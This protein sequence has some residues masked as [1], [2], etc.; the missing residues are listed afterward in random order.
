MTAVEGRPGVPAAGEQRIALRRRI[1]GVLVASQILGGLGVATGVA[2]ASVLAQRISG[3]ESLSG[4][5]PTAMVTGTAVASLPLAALMTAR[6]RRPGLVVGYLVGALGA[7]VVVVAAVVD[8]FPL[9]LCGMAGFGAAS[10][11]NL[12]ARFAAADLAEPD[13]RARAISNVVWATTIGAVLGPNIAAPAGRSVSGLGIPT[14][15][16]PFLWAAGIF[17]AAAVTVAVLLRPD[18]L[19]TARALAPVEERSAGGRSLRAGFAAVA[20]SPRARLAL[21]TVAMCHTAMVSVMSMTPVA[22][23]HHGASIDLIG[24]VISGHIA[25]MYAFSPLMGRLS[26]GVG[27][28]SGIGLAVGLLAC[29]A[30]LAGTADGS[31]GRTAVGLFVLGLGW[32]AGLVSG[33]ALL[34][35]SVPDAV[36]A[37]AQGLSDLVM[38]TAAGLGG[39][40]AG[41]VMATAGYGWLN[42]AAAC[43]LIPVGAL[44][45]FTRGGL[46][47]GRDAKARG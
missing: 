47:R 32:S 41:L 10:A 30:F 3:T 42:L 13:R 2:L 28:L 22:L 26:D 19:L 18:P 23:E 45:L 29:A 6:G 7:G 34:T 24:L 17:L 4:L 33:S 27:R 31:H 15:A 35:D 46:R 12:G 16:G 8:S 39:A 40:T 1:S 21:V 5:A 25:G 37:A 36:R 14:T 44:A 11:A 43:L 38:N 9:L 20:A